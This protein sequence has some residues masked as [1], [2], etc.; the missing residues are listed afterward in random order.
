M[1]QPLL[2]V[3]YVI[4][5]V[6]I[7]NGIDDETDN[8]LRERAKHALE[9]AGKA[10]LVSLHSAVR[11]VEG[12]SSVKI[13][14]MPDGVTGVIKIIADGGE[15]SEIEKVIN[16]TR[17][18]GIKVEFS[19][20]SPIYIDMNMTITLEVNMTSSKVSREVEAKIRG[21]ISSL[22]IGDNLVF[23]RILGVVLGV[24]GVYD[25]SEITINAYRRD[26]AEATTSTREN[27]GIRAEE[28]AIA[29]EINILIKRLE[30][31]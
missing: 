16:E 31:R 14:D 28:R 11:G 26:E 15:S 23:S 7:L 5:R 29:R 22:D 13:E 21:Y 18:A 9:V 6:D 3:E 4:N 8:E 17:A 20:P 27:I 19:R 12:V 30:N 24:D 10:T 1:P 25:V 2:G